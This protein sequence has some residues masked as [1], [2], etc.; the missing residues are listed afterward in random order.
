MPWALDIIKAQGFQYDS[1]LLYFKHGLHRLDNGLIELVPNSIH[2]LGK[3]L[4]V[5]GGF[6]FRATPWFFYCLY[7]HYL[8]HRNI[9][10]NFYTHSWELIPVERKLKMSRLKSFVQYFNT[11]SVSKKL[12]AMLDIFEF[13]TAQD[14]IAQSAKGPA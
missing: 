12:K 2:F 9:P 7:I 11:P 4:P 14:F 8:E 10:L 3:T 13:T 1:S 6:V 5:N